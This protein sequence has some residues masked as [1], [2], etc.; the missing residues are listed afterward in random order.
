[1]GIVR[2]YSPAIIC[3]GRSGWVGDFAVEEGGKPV[4]GPVRPF[5]WEKC[6][7]L[8]RTSWGYNEKQKLMTYDEIVRTLVEV[9]VRNG[10]LLLNFGPDRHGKIPASHAALTRRVGSWLGKVGDS[11]YGTRGGPWNPVD[12]QYGFTA[13]PGKIFVHLLAGY[14]GTEFTTPAIAERVTGCRDLFSGRAL[15]YQVMANGQVAIGGIDRTAHPADTVIMLTTEPT[16]RPER[17]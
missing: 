3:N 16:V 8:N 6:L 5:Y 7:N 15:A 14:A 10:N 2:K 13:K 1:M 12:G 9:V 17:P 11:I 4:T